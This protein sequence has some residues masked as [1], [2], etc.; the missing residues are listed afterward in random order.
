[1]RVF[2]LVSLLLALCLLASGC[3]KT[4]PPA[5][6]MVSEGTS[7]SPPKI[8]TAGRTLSPKESRELIKKLE[9][10]GGSA[11]ILERQTKLIEEISGAKLISGN[12]ATLLIDGPATY[13]AMFKAIGEAKDSI[14]LETFLFNDDVTGRKFADLLL[15]KRA[16]GVQVNVIYDS[17]GSIGTPAAFFQR[18][19]DGGISTLEFNPVN[20]LKVRKK[21]RI[22]RRDHRKILVV[23]GRVAFTGG[24]NISS[25]YTSKP[26]VDVK[27]K[28]AEKPWRDTHVM[29]EGPAVAEFQ[30]LFMGTWKWQNGPKLP[31]RKYFPPLKKEGDNLIMVIGSRWGEMNRLTYIMYYSAFVSAQKYIH[32][33]NSYFVPD[34]DTKDALSEAAERGVDVKLVLPGQSDIPTAYYAGRSYYED[35]LEAG[36]KIYERKGGVLHAKTATIDGVWST[37][38]STNMDMFSFANDNEANAVILGRDFAADMENMFENDLKESKEVT[39]EQWSK[40]PLF[41]RVREYISR[42]LK[43]WL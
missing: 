17:V 29:V 35:L 43:R 19:R 1:M 37:V 16:E 18:L 9:T 2:T 6:G 27:D 40:R 7:A 38:G 41:D 32:L 14:N 3:A 25:V 12:K 22:N 21:W 13:K 5:K 42:L 33:T 24:V 31:E 30:R 34:D 4:L 23:D 28:Q 8:E 15:K 39:R 20:P 10:E 11:D 36:V 26:S